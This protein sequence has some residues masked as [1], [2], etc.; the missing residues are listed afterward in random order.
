MY[1]TLFAITL[2][3][4][5]IASPACSSRSGETRQ[6][7]RELSHRVAPGMPR[8]EVEGVLTELNF[9]FAYVPPDLLAKVGENAP[10]GGRIDG[11][12]PYERDLGRITW[13]VATVELDSDMRA[14]EIDIQSGF[15]GF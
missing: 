8:A 15:S 1:R 13:V 14:T 6:L 10:P 2:I 11:H 12:S 3:S 5:L 7:V 4:A 9:S